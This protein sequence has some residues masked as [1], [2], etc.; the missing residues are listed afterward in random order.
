V[1]Y[2]ILVYVLLVLVACSI[3]DD[4]VELRVTDAD[5]EDTAVYSCVA[6]NLAGE[7]ERNFDVDVQRMFNI[8]LRI[9]C[10]TYWKKGRHWH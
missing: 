5:V 9:T 2:V 6:R 4:G 10:S 3:S 1:Q 8:T 7:M